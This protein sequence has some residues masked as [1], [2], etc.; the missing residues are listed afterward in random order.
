MGCRAC[1]DYR[2]DLSR[3]SISPQF[4]FRVLA[5]VFEM[6]GVKLLKL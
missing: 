2:E 5:S 4:S 6:S 3:G 1:P